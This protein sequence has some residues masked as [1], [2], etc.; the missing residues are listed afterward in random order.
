MQPGVR[1]FLLARL[2]PALSDLVLA[3]LLLA[4]LAALVLAGP[5]I[6]GEVTAEG[7]AAPWRRLPADGGEAGFSQNPAG[8]RGLLGF[9]FSPREGGAG[10]SWH[11]VFF[12]AGGGLRIGAQGS[13]DSGS[14]N[15]R[16]IVALKFDF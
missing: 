1:H 5:A 6:A 11:G 16:A 14:G 9:E 8:F 12:R 7:P 2:C 10:A 3:C 13:L 15:L 4:A